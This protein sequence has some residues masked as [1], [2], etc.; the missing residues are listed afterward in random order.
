[1]HNY[2]KKQ[3]HRMDLSYSG[4]GKNPIQDFKKGQN[5]FLLIDPPK[6][7]GIVKC[8]YCGKFKDATSYP[9]DNC[10]N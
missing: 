10:G 3:K 2:C 8:D 4:K 7:I 9:C 5:P 1:M 6:K